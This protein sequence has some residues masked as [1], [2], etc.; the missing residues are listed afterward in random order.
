MTITTEPGTVAVRFTLDP[1]FPVEE[2]LLEGLIDCAFP[3]DD[4]SFQV[5]IKD[6]DEA[7]IETLR[8]DEIAEFLGIESE[9]VT[10][11]EVLS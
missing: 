6:V 3:Q 8:T 10:Y 1:E 9:F 7:L 11:C 2:Y 5:I 4:G